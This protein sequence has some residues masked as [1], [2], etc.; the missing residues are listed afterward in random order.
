MNVTETIEV[1]TADRTL[2]LSIPVDKAVERYRV[3]VLVEPEDRPPFDTGVNE[4]PAGFF[5]RTAGAWQGE[6]VRA[7]QE[8]LPHRE[9]L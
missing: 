5:E 8:E 3:I 4:W 1:S 2:K 9:S 7:P 6:L